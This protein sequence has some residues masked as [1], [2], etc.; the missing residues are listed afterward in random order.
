MLLHLFILNWLEQSIYILE[1]DVCLF[2]GTRAF[3]GGRRGIYAPETKPE[4][5]GL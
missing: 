2:G 3:M 4:A 5:I 1:T